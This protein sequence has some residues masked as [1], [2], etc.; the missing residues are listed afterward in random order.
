M[1]DI[2]VETI[3][4]ELTQ[5]QT[6]L[7]ERLGELKAELSKIE[8]ALA[9]VNGALEA[10]RG[11]GRA[12]TRKSAATKQEV[13]EF[14]KTILQSKHVVKQG[15]LK[16]HVEALVTEAGKSRMGLALRI[17]EALNEPCFLA[18]EAGIQLAEVPSAE[19]P[20]I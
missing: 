19:Q 4:E 12:K 5:E 18:T 3:I 7:R 15:D 17:K 16:R 1:T 10:L 14:I 8:S 9:R 6:R 11:S 20:P 13:I 2:Q